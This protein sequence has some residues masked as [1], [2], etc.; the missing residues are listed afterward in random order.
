MINVAFGLLVVVHAAIYDT[1]YIVGTARV[2]WNSFL[3]LSNLIYSM[4]CLNGPDVVTDS[5]CLALQRSL[6]VDLLG[7]WCTTA[8]RFGRPCGS[9]MQLVHL[10]RI[11][12]LRVYA[13]FT[14]C[15]LRPIYSL[16]GWDAWLHCC[17]S[18][19]LHGIDLYP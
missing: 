10:L 2:Q 19:G 14:F 15:G 3:Y 1:S 4:P 6:D 13:Q 18:I 11:R 12:S 8:G 17:K 7:M 5:C 9:T 16:V